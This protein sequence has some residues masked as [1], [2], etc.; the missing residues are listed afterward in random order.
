MGGGARGQIKELYPIINGRLSEKITY[1]IKG[2]S[3]KKWSGVHWPRG[4][5]LYIYSWNFLMKTISS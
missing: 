3:G 5:T 2:S 4:Q 1:V